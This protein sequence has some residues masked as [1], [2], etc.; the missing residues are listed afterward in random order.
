MINIKESQTELTKPKIGII[1]GLILLV[2]NFCDRLWLSLDQSVPAWDQSN[3]LTYSLEYLRALQNPNFLEGE[4][5][6]QFWM[7]STKYPPLT[8][9]ASVPF[10][11]IWGLGNDCLLYTSPSPRDS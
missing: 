11:Q 1:L 10:Q 3:H 5:W 8:Y 9:L 4:W 6:R 7:L 2:S